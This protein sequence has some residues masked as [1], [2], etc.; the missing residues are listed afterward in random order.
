VNYKKKQNGVPFFM[1]H[2]V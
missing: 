1:K 2:C